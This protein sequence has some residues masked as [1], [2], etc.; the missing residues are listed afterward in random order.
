MT[1][2]SKQYILVKE[3]PGSP[4][5]GTILT[6]EPTGVYKDSVKRSAFLSNTIENSPE[7]WQMLKYRVTE[8]TFGKAQYVGNVFKLTDRIVGG[9]YTYV[10]PKFP[11][12]HISMESFYGETRGAL[13][14]FVAIHTVVRVEDGATFTVGQKTNRGVITGIVFSQYAATSGVLVQCGPVAVDLA[15]K[16]EA[17]AKAFA[18][19]PRVK[20]LTTEDGVDIFD[21][22]KCYAVDEEY[23]I[24]G[25]QRYSKPGSN[26]YFFST[27]VA[28]A[29]WVKDNKPAEP[30]R[31]TSDGVKIYAGQPYWVVR[32]Q[33]LVIV[34]HIASPN[35]APNPKAV[36]FSTE[37][38]AKGYVNMHKVLFSGQEIM[39]LILP[40]CTGGKKEF[41]DLIAT[42]VSKKVNAP[43]Q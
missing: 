2:V 24:W 19:Q 15:R 25:P 23:T 18:L 40:H 5:K 14:K 7:F 26:L 11:G 42:T 30:L 28:A 10:S 37:A 39:D 6:Q 22:D 27:H 16:L 13:D 9:Y 4:K 17:G 32:K 34:R 36:L 33:D 43:K 3:Y 12:Q 41:F 21:G 8:L 29:A 35:L 20:L 1:Q 38:G 31:V